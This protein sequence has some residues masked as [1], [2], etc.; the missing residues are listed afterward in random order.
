MTILINGYS[1]E[2][3]FFT[4]NQILDLPGVYVI[5]TQTSPNNF[6]VI[7]VGESGSL[8]TRIE[9]HDRQGCWNLNSVGD[10]AAAVLYTTGSDEARRSIENNIRA[11]YSPV[12]GIR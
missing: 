5:L 9:N 3:P 12:C 2:G 11:T 7:D 10:L 6:T 4:S 1:F 8:Q